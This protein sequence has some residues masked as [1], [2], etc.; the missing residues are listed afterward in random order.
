MPEDFDLEKEL[1]RRMKQKKGLIKVRR[2]LHPEESVGE[3]RYQVDKF[4]SLGKRDKERQEAIRSTWER[5]LFEETGRCS[6]G[7]QDITKQRPTMPRPIIQ[8][9]KYEKEYGKPRVVPMQPVPAPE[10]FDKYTREELI[11]IILQLQEDIAKLKAQR[12]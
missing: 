11:M 6:T 1:D 10:G 2:T 12:K 3:S 4:V 9:I 7:G 8:E 5:Q